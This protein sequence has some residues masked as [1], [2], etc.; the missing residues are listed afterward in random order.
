MQVAHCCVIMASTLVAALLDLYPISPLADRVGSERCSVSS[1]WPSF[2]TYLLATRA[3]QDWLDHTADLMC[4]YGVCRRAWAVDRFANASD[5][6]V[7]R[8]LSKSSGVIN[9]SQ[10]ARWRDVDALGTHLRALLHLAEEDSGARG[11]LFL[12]EDVEPWVQPP[13]LRAIVDAVLRR[14]DVDVA[15]LGGCWGIHA[16]SRSPGWRKL[17]G[18]LP[19]SSALLAAPPGS[20]DATRC[21]HLYVATQSGSRL[22][23]SLSRAAPLTLTFS[24]HINELHAADARLLTALVEPPVGCQVKG[25]ANSRHCFA[26]CDAVGMGARR[27]VRVGAALATGSKWHQHVSLADE[28]GVAGCGRTVPAASP[29]RDGANAGCAP[30]RQERDDADAA[31]EEARASAPGTEPQRERPRQTLFPSDEL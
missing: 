30:V 1:P 10:R 28:E 20:S 31:G 17:D 27:P 26:A 8:L 19:A 15:F 16:G 22:L 9:P 25:I 18:A 4:M 12:E 24:H 6:D 2:P 11:G 3:S 7:E 14:D 23:L 13:E 21:G 29:A 5:A